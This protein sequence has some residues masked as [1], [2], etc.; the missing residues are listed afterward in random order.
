[1]LESEERQLTAA[2]RKEKIRERYK[3]VSSDELDVIPAIKTESFYEDVREKRVGVYA[4]VSTD[5][6]RQTSS[7]ELQKNHYMDVIS[8]HE[9]WKLIN[10]YADEG[11][12][13]TSLQHR[14][15]FKKMIS[16]CKDGKLDLIVTKSVSRFARNVLDCIGYVRELAAMQPPI[17]V[18]FETEN[19][20]TLDSNS[21]MSLSFI[22]TLAQEESHNKSEI[23]NASIEMRFRRGIFLTPPLLGYDLDKEGHL[24]INEEEAKTVRL[25]FFMYLYGYTCCQIADTLTKLGRRTKKG[26]T[27]WSPGSI[28]QQLQNERHC[29]DVLA[30]K[31]WTPSYLNHKS[32]KNRQDRNQYRQREHHEAIVSRDDF[33]AV[34]RLI[35]NAKYGHKGIL[36]ELHVI[37]EGVFRGYV[38][39]NPRWSGFKAEDYIKASESVYDGDVPYPEDQTVEVDA[40]DFDLRGFEIARSQFFDTANK[41]SVSMGYAEIRF[42]AECLKKLDDVLYVELLVH[43]T[44][45]LFAVRPSTKDNKHAIRWSMLSDVKHNPRPIAATAYMPALYELFGWN[46]EYKYRLRGF[47]KMNDTE[48]LLLFDI[49]EPEIFL[50]NSD[51]PIDVD[52]TEK[53]PCKAVRAFP[54]QWA[55]DFGSEYYRHAQMAELAEFARSGEWKSLSPGEPYSEDKLNTTDSE[56]IKENIKNII[57]EMKEGMAG[58]E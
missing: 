25:I 9:G 6:P 30:R 42:G 32:K 39:V 23:M 40:G 18:F 54:E 10:I 45:M 46:K 52:M 22:S 47:R 21:E 36:P 16:D 12:S 34:Q 2:E 5:D 1:M 38:A 14:D 48:K 29:G 50:P 17:G 55:S 4:R 31:T 3:G 51:Q 53:I 56:E 27:H 26:N 15:S 41:V 58:N 7:Y 28:L 49:K 13:G 37:T 44:L 19:I 8:R 33:I 20:Y 35:S 57:I 11:I 24:V 43:P